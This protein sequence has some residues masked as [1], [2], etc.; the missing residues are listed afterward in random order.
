MICPY[1]LKFFK[2]DTTVKHKIKRKVLILNQID[3]KIRKE[4]LFRRIRKRG[5]AKSRK[6][7]IRDLQEL[8]LSKYIKLGKHTAQKLK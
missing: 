5:Y 4:K 6:T 7:F 8:E 1:C 2:I 3:K